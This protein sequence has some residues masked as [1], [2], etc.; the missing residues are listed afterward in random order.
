[1]GQSQARK[2][3]PRTHAASAILTVRHYGG[4]GVEEVVAEVGG[5]DQGGLPLIRQRVKDDF[6]TFY[7]KKRQERYRPKHAER[8]DV[9]RIQCHLH[10]NFEQYVA[11]LT[12]TDDIGCLTDR[13]Y[14]K[15]HRRKSQTVKH[16]DVVQH[17]RSPTWQHVGPFMSPPRPRSRREMPRT[18]TSTFRQLQFQLQLQQQPG[19]QTTTTTT[20]IQQ[21]PPLPP[22]VPLPVDI[23]SI[24][25]RAA[26]ASRTLFAYPSIASV[27]LATNTFPPQHTSTPPATHRHQR[28]N[29]S[30]VS[31][32]MITPVSTCPN[33]A[34]TGRSFLPQYRARSSSSPTVHHHAQHRHGGNGRSTA[35][36]RILPLIDQ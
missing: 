4:S 27:P 5:S 8:Q 12:Q 6:H 18:D 19:Q 24:S 1:M 11:K 25:N 21:R 15:R 9:V 33:D 2:I 35:R 29:S 23:G 3:S 16:D 26:L 28:G 13:S 7:A 10:T 14:G 31:L 34:A 36:R 30:P 22:P 20:T 32:P 17:T